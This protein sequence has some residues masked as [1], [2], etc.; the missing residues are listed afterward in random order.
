MPFANVNSTLRAKQHPHPNLLP[1]GEGTLSR[2]FP[3]GRDS[4]EPSRHCNSS[5]LDRVSPYQRLR[6]TQTPSPFGRVLG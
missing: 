5:R 4:V 1:Q 2:R 6:A 3:V